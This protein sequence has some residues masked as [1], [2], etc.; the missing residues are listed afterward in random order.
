M[1]KRF[2][3]LLVLIPILLTSCISASATPVVESPTQTIE[4]IPTEKV[5]K[6]PTSTPKGDEGP[7]S[8]LL[9][10]CTVVSALPEPPAEFVE[11]FSVN[12]ND[13]VVGP[14]DAS[15]TLIEYGDFQ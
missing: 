15:V 4:I 6:Q 12:E 7:Q 9:S 2:L 1:Q 8:V 10:E 11:L 13:W 5:I 3:T 14:E